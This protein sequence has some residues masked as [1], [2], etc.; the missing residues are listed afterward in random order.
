MEKIVFDHSDKNI[1][2]HDS[3]TFTRMFINA[4]EIFDKNLRWAAHFFLNP[5]EAPK[6]KNWFNFKSNRPAPQVK[7]LKNFQDDLAKLTQNLKFR[8]CRKNTLMQ[9][10]NEDKK[11]IMRTDKIIVNADKTSNKYLVAKENYKVMVKK[12]VTA[13]FKIAKGHDVENA[14]K[15]HQ[16]IVKDLELTERVFKTTPRDA[17]ITI[18]D[19]KDDFMNNTKCRLLNPSKPE[20]GQ[21]SKII[22]QNVVNVVKEKTA[23]KQW[24][25]T[26][27]VLMWF[28]QVKDKA[29]K[30]FINFDICNFYPSI[31]PQLLSKALEWAKTMVDIAEDDWNTIMKSKKSFLYANGQIWVKKGGVNFDIAQGAYDGAESCEIV[32]L[33]LQNQLKNKIEGFDFGLYRDDGLGL[34]QTTARQAEKIKQKIVKVLS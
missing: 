25:S 15:E 22:L 28:K 5:N 30:T 29:R 17:F 18:K 19:H 32:G 16:K 21:V 14:N 11:R 1:P 20:V 34:V 33:Y 4:V 2:I 8:N 23:L 31:T 12:A 24:K 9:K 26:C 10:L 7:E 6:N 27:E 13:D 3:G